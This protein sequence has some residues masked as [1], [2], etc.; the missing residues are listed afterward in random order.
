MSAVTTALHLAFHL[1]LPQVR[2][3]FAGEAADVSHAIRQLVEHCGAVRSAAKALFSVGFWQHPGIKE[4][5]ARLAGRRELNRSG[6][7]AVVEVLFHVDGKTLMQPLPM[8]GQTPPPPPG[9]GGPPALPP[10]GPG[11]PGLPPRDGPGPCPGPAGLSATFALHSGFVFD[12]FLH[13]LI[14]KSWEGKHRC[15]F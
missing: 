8:F 7:A 13:C 1:T 12:S 9:P 10:P 6:R 15:N 3:R 5:F 11:P 14:N 4:V 2:L